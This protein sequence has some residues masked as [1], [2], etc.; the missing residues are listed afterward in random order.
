MLGLSIGTAIGVSLLLAASA[1]DGYVQGG[2]WALALLIDVGLPF[3]FFAEGWRLM[4]SHF[5]ERHGL[6]LI[7]ALGESIVAIGVGSDAVVD[8]G[9]VL[10][11]TVG[12]GI[13]AAMWWLYFDVSVWLAEDMLAR[14]TPGREQNELARDAYSLLHFP[15]VAG[16]VL[17]ALGLKN[18]L[19]HVGDALEPVPAVALVGGVAL[20]LVAHVGFKLRTSRTLS[21]PR[22]VGAIG[23]LLLY[24]LAVELPSVAAVALVLSVLCAVIVYE[25]VR[26]ADT[27][28][29]VRSQIHG[30][31][32]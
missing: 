15:M 23:V 27:R 32:A 5:A 7:I 12:V 10:A 8:S 30:A 17:A 13:A 3:L 26:Y 20:Y 4:A 28:R 9:T 31:H 11:A 21:R 16:I 2:L 24:P 22:L 29:D 25:L 6:I 18:T 19:A 14:A 1:T